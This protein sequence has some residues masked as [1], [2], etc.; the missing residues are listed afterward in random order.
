V[1]KLLLRTG[2]FM[3]PFLLSCNKKTPTKSGRQREREH[4]GLNFFYIGVMFWKDKGEGTKEDFRHL[5]T[6]ITSEQLCRFAAHK[7]H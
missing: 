3:I 7:P 5:K 4:G 6:L 2:R 1:G